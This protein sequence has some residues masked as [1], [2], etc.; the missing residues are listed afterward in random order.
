MADEELQVVR[1]L[2]RDT[3]H[4]QAVSSAYYAMFYAAKAALLAANVTVKSHEGAISEFGRLFVSTGHVDGRLG[5]MLADRY[6]D[7]LDSDY[8]LWPNVTRE[9]A[10]Q[11]MQD[12]GTFIA[13][14]RELVE[15]ELSKRGAFPA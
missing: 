8:S 2:L 4:R 15:E 5:A 3:R 6:E 14:A 1:D 11:A 7:W 9:L 10:Q 12:A 13:R